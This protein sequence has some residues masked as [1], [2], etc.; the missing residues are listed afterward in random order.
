M[1]IHQQTHTGQK[2]YE[3]SH[4]QKHFSDSSTLQVHQRQHTNDS[5]YQCHL[6]DR[7]TKQASNLKSHY[8]Y[9]HKNQDITSRQIRLNSRIFGRFE[10]S[11]IDAHF[12]EYGDL[13]M[14]LDKGLAEFNREE[15]EKKLPR[16][17]GKDF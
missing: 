6:C 8:K 2:P 13:R 15:K 17:N 7:R 9:F 3:C 10:Q 14:L 12:N 4:C 1:K 5:P 11:E 16:E